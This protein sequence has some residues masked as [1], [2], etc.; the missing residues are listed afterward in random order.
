MDAETT[1]RDGRHDFDFFFG[2]WRVRHRR[3]RERLVGSDQWEEFLGECRAWECPAGLGNQDEVR[4]AA[5]SGEVIG[6][7]FRFFD[8]ESGQWSIYWIDSH[9][10]RLDPPVLGR[11]EG[12]TGVFE[13]DDELAGRPIRVRFQWTR[14]R[15]ARPRWEQAFSADGGAT[16]ETNWEME[17]ERLAG[18]GEAR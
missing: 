10:R 15:S 5:G 14:T 4:F 9:R 1:T 6:L 18:A 13:S 3:L 12:E 11:F 16:W 7:S 8:A 2:S 17:F